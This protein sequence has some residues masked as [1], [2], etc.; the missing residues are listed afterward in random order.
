MGTNSIRT[1]LNKDTI[2]SEIK[3][4]IGA[5]TEKKKAFVVVEGIDDIKFLKKFCCDTTTMYESFSGKGGV[6]EIVNSE[7]IDNCRVIGIRDKDYCRY[8]SDDR[9]FF[10]DK[11]C[12]EMM[13]LSFDDVSDGICSEFY[14]GEKRAMCLRSDIVK[15][16]LTISYLRKRNEQESWGISFK[17]IKFSKLTNDDGTIDNKSVIRVLKESNPRKDTSVLDGVFCSY[18]DNDD[19]FEITNGHD[20]LHYFR[21]ICE[22]ENRNKAPSTDTIAAALRSAFGKNHFVATTLFRQVDMYSKSNGFQVWD[23]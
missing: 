21:Y 10:Y 3:L 7:I 19:Y 4:S 23:V 1:N 13:M 12:L 22:R 6:E 18:D 16:L 17:A 15:E 8:R 14:E 20:Y 2:I 5:D 11:C 9:I